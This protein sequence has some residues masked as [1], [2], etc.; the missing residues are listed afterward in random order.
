MALSFQ[1]EHGANVIW[2]QI[3]EALRCA[4]RAAVARRTGADVFG[5]S[6][7]EEDFDEEYLRI[8]LMTNIAQLHEDLLNLSLE[9]RANIS[10][11]LCNKTAYFARFS[12]IF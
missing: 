2:D 9:K 3:Q 5:D 4:K 1:S 6:L 12:E 11:I 7:E 10:Q 8:P